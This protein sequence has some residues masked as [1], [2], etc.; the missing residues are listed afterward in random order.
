MTND[1]ERPVGV[2]HWSF[3]IRH[4]VPVRG[5]PVRRI[6]I[7]MLALGLVGV[8]GVTLAQTAAQPAP[9]FKAPVAGPAVPHLPPAGGGIPDIVVPPADKGPEIKL[10]PTLPDLVM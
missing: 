8:L 2:R 9:G 3:V 4:L 7:A 10:P 6:H 5:W 1:E